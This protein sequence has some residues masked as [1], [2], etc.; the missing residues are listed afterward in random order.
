MDIDLQE[1]MQRGGALK[2]QGSRLQ[3]V[4][5]SAMI[6]AAVIALGAVV[7]AGLGALCGAVLCIDRGGLLGAAIG[8]IFVPLH[9]IGTDVPRKWRA[10]WKALGRR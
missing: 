2:P 7:F 3:F 5:V 1:R 10:R 4:V 6:A 8:A 9:A